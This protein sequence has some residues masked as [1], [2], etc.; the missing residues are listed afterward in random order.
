MKKYLPNLISILSALFLPVFAFAAATTFRDL[1]STVIVPII[2]GI[3]RI[4]YVS[5]AIGLSYGVVMYF[6]NSDNEKKREE[7]KGYLLW[8]VIGITVAFGLWG[9]VAILSD[10]LGWGNV[11]I[12]IIQP[13]SP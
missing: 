9:I 12:P 3:L 5:L 6:V 13:P 10:T 4:F 1:T 7:I 2:K 11:G 8:G